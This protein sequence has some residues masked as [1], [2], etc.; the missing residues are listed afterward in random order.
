MRRRHAESL[1]AGG[2]MADGDDSVR[3]QGAGWD[4][5]TQGVNVHNPVAARVVLESVPDEKG[6]LFAVDLDAAAY[7][8][9][10]KHPIL[11]IDLDGYRS[12]ELF[13]TL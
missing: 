7:R 6:H 13:F 10:D 12:P 1:E 3:L 8:F 2:G 4:H 5:V 9:G 11:V